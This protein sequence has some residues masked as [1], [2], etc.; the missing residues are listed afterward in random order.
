M[1]SSS[2]QVVE[3]FVGKPGLD[4]KAKKR[5]NSRVTRVRV[6]R[7]IHSAILR[8]HTRLAEEAAASGITAKSSLHVVTGSMVGHLRKNQRISIKLEFDTTKFHGR[9]VSIRSRLPNFGMRN[10]TTRVCG[11]QAVLDDVRFLDSTH[12]SA[13]MDLLIE[14][15]LSDNHDEAMSNEVVQ[16]VLPKAIKI[17]ADGPRNRASKSKKN[18]SKNNNDCNIMILDSPPITPAQTLSH[19]SSLSSSSSSSSEPS[20]PSSSDYFSGSL[21]PSPSQSSAS[22]TSSDD[23]EDMQLKPKQLQHQQADHPLY[24]PAQLMAAYFYSQIVWRELEF[25]Q[26]VQAFEHI[27]NEDNKQRGEQQWPQHVIDQIVQSFASLLRQQLF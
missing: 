5:D 11:S 14:V 8:V 21:S 6:K 10:N 25:N 2:S 17:T 3:S 18:K 4:E 22:A 15:D 27:L 12:R 24:D 26:N 13:K 9:R 1:M 7:T 19:D 16:F 20:S 23:D